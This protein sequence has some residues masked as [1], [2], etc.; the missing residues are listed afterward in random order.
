M[1]RLDPSSQHI[2]LD[3]QELLEVAAAMVQHLATFKNP[4]EVLHH[5][6]LVLHA[7]EQNVSFL[8]HDPNNEDEEDYLE[9][10]FELGERTEE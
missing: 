7:N 2:M 1:A 8:M 6:E 10:V 3:G 4:G 9:L 5:I